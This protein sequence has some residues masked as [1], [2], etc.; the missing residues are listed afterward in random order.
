M[1]TDKM[2]YFLIIQMT[3]WHTQM[4]TPWI[5]TVDG[6]KPGSMEAFTKYLEQADGGVMLEGVYEDI[7]GTYYYAFGL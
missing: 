1:Y 6:K 3:K 5:L 7:P 2:T 4:P